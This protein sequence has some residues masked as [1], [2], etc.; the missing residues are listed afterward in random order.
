MKILELLC[1]TT[2]ELLK[3]ARYLINAYYMKVFLTAINLTMLIGP[4]QNLVSSNLLILNT[5]V[6]WLNTIWH[7]IGANA[8]HIGK[9]WMK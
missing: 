7:K 2:F 4:G 8:L 3:I 6:M 5:E 1:L 9:L